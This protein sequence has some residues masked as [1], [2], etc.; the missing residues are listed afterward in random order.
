Q[1]VAAIKKH[2]H[3]SESF[4]ASDVYNKVMAEFYPGRPRPQHQD[5]VDA[6]NRDG[7]PLTAPSIGRR[8]SGE[9]GDVADGFS[10]HVVLDWSGERKAYCVMPRATAPAAEEP[11]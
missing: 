6:F 4:T 5:L 9:E 7:R 11:F 1:R 8:R 2:F 10:L 3:R